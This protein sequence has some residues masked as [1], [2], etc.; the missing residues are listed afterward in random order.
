VTALA[1][2]YELLQGLKTYFLICFL[3]IAWLGVIKFQACIYILGQANKIWKDFPFPE[4][5][6]S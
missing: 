1:Y 2:V 3:G 4:S 6:R 5:D